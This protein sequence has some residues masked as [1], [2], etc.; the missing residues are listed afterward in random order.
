MKIK[1]LTCDFHRCDSAKISHFF[2]KAR[3]KLKPTANTRLR[4][5][6]FPVLFYRKN[7]PCRQRCSLIFLYPVLCYLPN[8]NERWK[9]DNWNTDEIIIVRIIQADQTQENAKVQRKDQQLGVCQSYGVLCLH[10]LF[11]Y[12]RTSWVLETGCALFL[13]HFARYNPVVMIF[14]IKTSQKAEHFK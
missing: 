11:G 2:R 12:W 6:Q 5:Q 7:I 1:T 10:G 3:Q 9:T 8:G 14:N 4:K 13:S